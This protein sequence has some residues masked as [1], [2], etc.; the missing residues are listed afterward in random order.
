MKTL[1]IL[2]LTS[3]TLSAQPIMQWS[4]A[5]IMVVS[6]KSKDII[7]PDV[8]D[9]AIVDLIYAY[10]QQCKKDSFPVPYKYFIGIN[11]DGSLKEECR[12]EYVHREPTFEGLIKYIHAIDPRK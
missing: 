1:I 10:E 2:L 5:D 3:T 7:K 11:D 6:K 12:I 8:I 9:L 4:G